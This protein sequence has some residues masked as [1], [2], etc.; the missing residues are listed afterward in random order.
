MNCCWS[1]YC[2]VLQKDQKSINDKQ[3][4]SR[5]SK[6]QLNC[7]MSAASSSTSEYIC[8]KPTVV[9]TKRYSNQHKRF[10]TN[11]QISGIRSRRNRHTTPLSN[12]SIPLEITIKS[13]ITPDSISTI[14]SE[15]SSTGNFTYQ[16]PRCELASVLMKSSLNRTTQAQEDYTISR[17]LNDDELSFTSLVMF[18]D[19]ES[20]SS[21]STSSS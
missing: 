11:K 6:T 9:K 15:L 10:N 4:P 1:M 18:D 21:N 2:T 19:V 16:F 14:P 12:S 8:T 20:F 3:F 17:P 13:P 7:G 5:F